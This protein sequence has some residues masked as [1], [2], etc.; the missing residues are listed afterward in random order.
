MFENGKWSVRNGRVKRVGLRTAFPVYDEG[1][2]EGKER[3]TN[4]KA[5]GMRAYLLRERK[6]KNDL[7]YGTLCESRGLWLSGSDLSVYER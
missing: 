1:T 5:D 7:R 2:S 4:G 6:R 3:Q